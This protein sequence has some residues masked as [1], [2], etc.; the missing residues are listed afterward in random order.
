MPKQTVFLLT[1]KFPF[2]HQET[3]LF[4]ELPYLVKEFGKVILIPYDEF[5]YLESANRI[6]ESEQLRVLRI[7]KM[8]NNLGF[9]AK[10]KRERMVWGI[11]AYE[12]MKG[13]EPGNHFK[14]RKRNLSQ[15]RQSYNNAITLKNFIRQ[16]SF[17]DVILYNYWLHGGIIISGMLNKLCKPVTYP[18]VSRAHAYDVY[19]KD[20]YTLYPDSP[21]LFLGFE[22]W[23]VFH[24]D[25][26]YPIS[27][28][29]LHHF[30][31]LFPQLKQKFEVARLG[32]IEQKSVGS[33][34]QTEELILVSCSNI[35][36]NKRIYRIPE[37]ISLLNKQV[38][39]FHFGKGADNDVEKLKQEINKYDLQNRCVLMG[40]KPNAEVI[41]FYKTNRID[42]FLN[43]SQVEGIP[44]SLMEAASFAIPMLAT[45]TVGNPEIVNDEN[46]FL[47]EVNFDA[48]QIADRLNTYFDD[49]NAIM[50]KREASYKTFSEKY[51]AAVNYPIFITNIKQVEHV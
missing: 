30:H 40:F 21:Y 32:V 46:G 51:N 13:R 47:V 38:K 17:K 44:V 9:V 43:L 19:H 25:K 45:K 33:P 16:Y 14:Y 27:T 36:D 4:N 23:K 15:L 3:Y 39:W 28:H 37:I 1:K 42:L 22:T 24:T 10:L 18:V 49:E 11:L 35:N 41:D 29:A 2:G 34:V 8:N 6:K 31:K 7:N 12:L 20:W 48:K 26:I 5:D 50:K